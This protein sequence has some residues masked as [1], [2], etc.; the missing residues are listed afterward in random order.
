MNDLKFPFRQL[1]KNPGFTAVPVLA[2]ALG[3][4]IGALAQDVLQPASPAKPA[5]PAGAS[6]N[7]PAPPQSAQPLA[8]VPAI[9]DLFDTYQVVGLSDLHGCAE[10]LAL[11]EQLVRTPDFSRKVNDLTWEPGNVRFQSL[12]LESTKAL[13]SEPRSWRRGS[14]PGRS[15]L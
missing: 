13:G 14:N 5:A 6:S 10:L 2:L 4:D 9:L 15:P 11:M 8:A 12:I 1:L 3:I 7:K